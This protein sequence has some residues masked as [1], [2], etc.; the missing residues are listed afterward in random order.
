MVSVVLVLLLNKT[1]R[2]ALKLPEMGIVSKI[3]VSL[4]EIH[5]VSFFL[6]FKDRRGQESKKIWET[7][8]N[9]TVQLPLRN[10]SFVIK[11]L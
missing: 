2:V 10:Q 9:T 7:T 1:V 6:N 11:H 4:G 5:Q 8:L 3:K